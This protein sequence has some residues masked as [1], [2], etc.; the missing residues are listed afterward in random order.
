MLETRVSRD[1]TEEGGLLSNA[2]VRRASEADFQ[3]ALRHSR[4][5]RFLRLA[6]P[7]IAVA[8]ILAPLLF[9][10][11][12]S[13]AIVVPLGDF[14]RLLLSGGKLAMES[15]RLTGFTKDNRPYEVQA[16]RAEHDVATPHLVELH[17]I[18]SKIE[19]GDHGRADMTALRGV[20]DTK[21][22]LLTLSGGIF[23]QTTEGYEGRL[24]EAVVD[25]RAGNVVSQHP[26]FLKF[27]QG[28]LTADSMD[29]RENGKYARFD[30]H[31]VMNVTLPQ[32]QGTSPATGA[33]R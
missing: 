21:T 25:V 23:L 22:E 3:R 13:L 2:A 8:A 20:F 10:A 14:G 26:V 9:T 29:M 28:D 5:V 11:V 19:M 33:A 30:G 4:R 18:R 12:R 27:L 17:E 24:S 6:V 7:T 32:S 16:A 1:G 31:V 15:P